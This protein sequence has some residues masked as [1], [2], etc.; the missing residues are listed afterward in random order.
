MSEEPRYVTA[1]TDQAY[2]RQSDDPAR[3]ASRRMAARSAG[4]VALL[5]AGLALGASE[6]WLGSGILGAGALATSPVHLLIYAVALLIV[7]SASRDRQGPP[8][9]HPAADDASLSDLSH[10]LRTPLNAVI[11]FSQL[12]LAEVHGPLGHPKYIDYAK[13]VSEC[14][15]QLVGVTD[16][17]LREKE[18]LRSRANVAA[19]H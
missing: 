18:A 8:R 3:S 10:G 9:L 12:M 19:H 15:S 14:G 7:I 5:A 11:G 4:L 13:H 1:P 17:I 6:A 16:Q 2:D